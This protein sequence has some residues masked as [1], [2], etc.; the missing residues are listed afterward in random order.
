MTLQRLFLWQCVAR[1]TTVR[2]AAGSNLTILGIY[3][4]FVEHIF[5]VF[6]YFHYELPF[7]CQCVHKTY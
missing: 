4:T 7:I 6:L 5:I 3:E 1:L 2:K